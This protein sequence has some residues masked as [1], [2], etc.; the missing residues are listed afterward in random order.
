[1]TTPRQYRDNTPNASQIDW[2]RAA[3]SGRIRGRRRGG[4][5]DRRGN[6]AAAITKQSQNR[7]T[8]AGEP[9]KVHP[10]PPWVDDGDA[11]G[12]LPPTRPAARLR[13]RSGSVGK[14]TSGDGGHPGG[15]KGGEEARRPP[16]RPRTRD[17]RGG[18]TKPEAGGTTP[19]QPRTRPPTGRT[20]GGADRDG[21]CLYKL[22]GVSPDGR[23]Q[24]GNL[25][26]APVLWGGIQI[27]ML[28]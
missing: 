22:G 24:H 9:N 27:P 14:R 25:D 23:E 21:I 28:R 6:P 2:S 4:Q 15:R 7:A 11:F 26:G 5:N 18:R 19:A 16:A 10:P 3:A 20:P 13:A 1:M 12:V 17:K 8:E